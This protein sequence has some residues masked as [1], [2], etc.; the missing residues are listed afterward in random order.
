M[1]KRSQNVNL[2]GLWLKG[3]GLS[4]GSE[5]LDLSSRVQRATPSLHIQPNEL[6]FARYGLAKTAA[7]T[8]LVLILLTTYYLLL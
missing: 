7:L 1:V 3:H 2:E 4:V 6:I 8:M 5:V